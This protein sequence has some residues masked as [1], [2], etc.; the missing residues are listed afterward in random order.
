VDLN[1]SDLEDVCDEISELMNQRSTGAI[2]GLPVAGFRS[3]FRFFA[4]SCE[5]NIGAVEQS[6]IERGCT[7]VSNHLPWLVAGNGLVSSK[8]TGNCQ[9]ELSS[10]DFEEYRFRPVVD[11]NIDFGFR[12]RRI[13]NPE[14][15]FL[16]QNR[17]HSSPSLM[18][19]RTR[20]DFA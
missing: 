5:T 7:M 10:K 9:S 6:A 12:T 1:E 16:P 17:E 4:R 2:Q 20:Q 3:S 13:I 8:L 15:N 18:S 14:H 19:K 11:I